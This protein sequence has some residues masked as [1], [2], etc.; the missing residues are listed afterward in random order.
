MGEHTDL[1][2]LDPVEAELFDAILDGIIPASA[3]GALP[4]AGALGL[5]NHVAMAVR[6]NPDLAP[7]IAEGLSA[8]RRFAGEPVADGAPR[9]LG[10]TE[11]AHLF[12]E[13]ETA[14][15]TF[16]FTLTLHTYI[17]YYQHPEVLAGLGLDP[18]PPHPHGHEIAPND[19]S[20]LDPIRKR[21]PF[22]RTPGA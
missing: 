16:I 1:D 18:R 20:L 6:Q 17:G 15:P 8:L 14:A 22:F 12:R 10:P 13:M 21:R 7:T 5:R 4:A 9:K 19:L 2:A 3:D 11:R